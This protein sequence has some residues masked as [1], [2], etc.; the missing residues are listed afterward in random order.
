MLPHGSHGSRR[1]ERRGQHPPRL[2]RDRTRDRERAVPR[3]EGEEERRGE[4]EDRRNGRLA[5]RR[6]I[7]ALVGFV[8]NAGCRGARGEAR[9]D[10]EGRADGRDAGGCRRRFL[11]AAS[12]RFEGLRRSV[13]GHGR[14]ASV[15]LRFARVVRARSGRE[16]HRIGREP[17]T[18]AEVEVR[19][20]SQYGT[21]RRRDSRDHSRF[22]RQV[23][24]ERDAHAAG[25]WHRPDAYLH[26]Q[27]RRRRGER[28]ATRRVGRGS[29]S[30]CGRGRMEGEDACGDVGIGE[31]GHEGGRRGRDA[32]RC[33][34]EGWGA[35]HA[36]EEQGSGEFSRLGEWQ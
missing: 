8:G 3:Q 21:R 13:E 4:E 28:G 23:F 22:Q 12:D 30:V 16:Y 29:H 2:L 19:G 10:E 35:G 7:D 5:H 32:G 34:F 17:T 36:D 24:V 27:S 9:R 31:E 15:L 6:G 33:E 1:I 20:V 14:T 18:G 26:A 11:P 25:R